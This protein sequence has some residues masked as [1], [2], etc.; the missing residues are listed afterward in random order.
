MTKFK[1]QKKSDLRS[2]QIFL[3]NEIPL[4]NGFDLSV[5][6]FF[7]TRLQNKTEELYSDVTEN[8]EAP[9]VIFYKIALKMILGKATY[10]VSPQRNKCRK[11]SMGHCWIEYR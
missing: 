8:T 3:R 10:W 5:H 9:L 11:T 7:K 1:R 6:F 4:W 2:Y